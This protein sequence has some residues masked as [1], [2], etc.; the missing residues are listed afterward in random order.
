MTSVLTVRASFGSFQRLVRS[1]F[2]RPSI[3]SKIVPNSHQKKLHFPTFSG[4]VQNLMLNLM[5]PV[6]FSG[7]AGKV[8]F[9]CPGGRFFRLF[10]G[11]CLPHPA[12]FARKFDP[13]P[14]FRFLTLSCVA[15]RVVPSRTSGHAGK[16][17][18]GCPEHFENSKKT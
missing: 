5:T 7:D 9:G 6:W 1:G 10:G 8:D 12:N 4:Q 16:V 15:N 11:F 17:D 18:F 13:N 3:I 14:S 2:L